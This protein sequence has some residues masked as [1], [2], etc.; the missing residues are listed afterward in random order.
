MVS[1]RAFVGVVSQSHVERGVEGG[2]AQL[3][4]GKHGP[5]TRMRAGDW[6]AY[7]SPRTVFRGGEPLQA[8]TA[9][10][11]MV[12]EETFQLD[13]GGGFVPWRRK[14]EFL[15]TRGVAPLALL[16]PRL[17]FTRPGLNWGLLARR[18]HFEVTLEDAALIAQALGVPGAVA[19]GRGLPE[20][21]GS[22][23]LLARAG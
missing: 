3:C 22:A 1:P 14:V 18:G 12:D 15:P 9:L 2:F 23:P 5:L 7:Y 17:S 20:L 11:R 21:R 4:H 10:G 19:R 16:K 8:F 13:L 6:L